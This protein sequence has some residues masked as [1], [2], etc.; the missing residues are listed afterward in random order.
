MK[1]IL[2]RYCSIALLLLFLFPLVEKEIH[3]MEHMND[4]HCTATDKHFHEQ[5]HTCSL[6]D[7]SVPD[8]NELEISY[9]QFSTYGK[10]ISFDLYTT[11]LHTPSPFQ[12]IPSRGPP[13]I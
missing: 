8:S 1:E 9:Y 6:C 10:N 7:Y 13:I 5:E 4:F 11:C 12:D 2:N 3:A